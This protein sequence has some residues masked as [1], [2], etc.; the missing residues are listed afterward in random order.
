MSSKLANDNDQPTLVFSSKFLEHIKF[1]LQFW[2][3]LL[4]PSTNVV[5]LFFCEKQFNNKETIL[6]FSL[7]LL[8]L[9]Q[10]PLHVQ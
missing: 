1:L 2:F 7:K 9:N 6:S 3:T 8:F 4:P 10:S 5:K